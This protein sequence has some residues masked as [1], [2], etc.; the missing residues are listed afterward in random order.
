MKKI[1]ILSL[2]IGIFNDMHS[3]MG[4]LQWQRPTG[5]TGYDYARETAIT[6]DGGI[7]TTGYTESADGDVAINRGNGDCWITRTDNSGNLQWEHTYGGSGFDYG[8]SVTNTTDGGYIFAGYT[9]SADGDVSSNHGAGDAWVVKIDNAGAIQWEK[10][11][12][13]SATEN[14][15]CIRA[16]SDGGYIFC[17][18][19]ES[20]NG[21]VSGY[22]GAGDCWIVKI[23][24]A[25]LIQWQK[26]MGG[27]AYDYAQDIKQTSDGG[28]VVAGGTNSSDGNVSE[29]NGNGDCW[30]VKLDVSGNIS[31]EKTFGG[32]DY[33]FAQA[34]E[35]TT[36]GG[37]VLAGYTQS[38]D[39][40]ITS[41]HGNGDCW[42]I[43]CNSAGSMEWQK[44]LGSTA[45]DYAYGI[46]EVSGCY[47]MVGYASANDGDVTGNHGDYDCWLA[48]LD[49]NGA[50]QAEQSY[51]GT[52]ED[53]GY[54]IR[55]GANGS[56]LIAGYT[57]SADGNVAGNH[58]GGDCWLI[59]VNMITNG[60]N[61]NNPVGDVA[62]LPSVGNGN[63]QLSGVKES[64]T[65][66]VF[67]AS[68]KLVLKKEVDAGTGKLD[69]T[70]CARGCYFYSLTANG[71]QS[72]AG[73]LVVQ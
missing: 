39:I 20:N 10:T 25:G 43:K 55:A 31:W 37:F 59:R 12:G 56:C 63:F 51:G 5:G 45:N 54:S 47:A 46:K 17:G 11:F 7:I 65:L 26:C 8:Y 62:I 42:V 28:F 3:Q 30:L 53:I 18:Y 21:D 36:D 57:G 1:I 32:T 35:E 70:N 2:F 64:S 14:V 52:G 68:G 6:P 69:M 44:A 24:G 50:L 40:D 67:D 9:E 72:D 27:T 66:R 4:L 34:V 23:D 16:T 60:I 33:D 41:Q 13:G 19:T 22:L 38:N 61:E 29:Q 73:K 58:G 15:Q 49:E 71:V 48:I